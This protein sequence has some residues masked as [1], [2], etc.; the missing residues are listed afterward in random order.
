MPSTG[1]RLKTAQAWHRHQN[2]VQMMEHLRTHPCTD[3]GE[4]DP[5]VLDFD[6]LPGT[7]KRFEIARAVNAS[8]RGWPSILSEIQKCEVVWANCHR[9]RTA[10]RAGHRKHL[11][12]TGTPVPVPG[13]TPGHLRVPHGG[14]A[15][16][17]RGCPCEAC[18]ERRSAYA[19]QW[20]AK[21]KSLIRATA[22]PPSAGELEE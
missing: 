19:R 13:H 9:R 20:R 16:G 12:A 4:P 1:E 18:R 7:D 8:K 11:L 10:A 21:R 22:V 14:G 15:K 2:F 5:V 3:C 17:R 6:H